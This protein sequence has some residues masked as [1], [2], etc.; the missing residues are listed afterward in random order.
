MKLRAVIESDDPRP[1]GKPALRSSID[2]LAAGLDP[3]QLGAGALSSPDGAVTLM[4]VGLDEPQGAAGPEAVVRR[5]VAD[6]SGQ[7]VSSQDGALL[8]SFA[9]AHAGLHCAV[10]LH[11]ELAASGNAAVPPP[12]RTGVHAG[13]VIANPD[14]LLGRNVIL[15]A[16][17]AGAAGAGEILV[18][19]ALRQYTSGD[20]SFRFEDRGEFHFR[21]LHGE[22]LVFAVRWE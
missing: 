2:D 1:A 9:S 12:V 21:G 3:A 6:H 19:S 13:F 14:Q 17:I 10:E 20:P 7:V 22:H 18:S 4:L 5:L 11:R 8:A 15:A 16:R